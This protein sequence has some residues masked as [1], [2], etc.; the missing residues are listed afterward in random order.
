MEGIQYLFISHGDDVF[1]A[2]AYQKYL[3]QKNHSPL[4]LAAQLKSEIVLEGDKPHQIDDAAFH[5][6]PG[7]TEGQIS[8]YR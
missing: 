5:F 8:I 4:E 3:R 7:N 6:T 1:D 2:E